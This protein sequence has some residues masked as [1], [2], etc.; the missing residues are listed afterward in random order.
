[1]KTSEENPAHGN[2]GE[3][4]DKP[5]HEM[6]IGA[7]HRVS[8]LERTFCYQ[9]PRSK[10]VYRALMADLS[11]QI[12]HLRWAT[13]IHPSPKLD[14]CPIPIPNSPIPIPNSEYREE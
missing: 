5:V 11:Q 12:N 13:R 3:V 14:L 2:G 10:R 8:R 6:T 7:R 4:P 9:K 1:V